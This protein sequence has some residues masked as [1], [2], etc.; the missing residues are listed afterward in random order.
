M[1]G[2]QESR[3]N[4]LRFAGCIEAEGCEEASHD[5]RRLQLC[6]SGKI[7]DMRRAWILRVMGAQPNLRF[8]GCI[9]AEGSEEASRVEDLN[10]LPAL[11][12]AG[13]TLSSRPPSKA[14]SRL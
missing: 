6:L 4:N 13:N 8:A 5:L 9:E 1:R 14:A 3:G 10:R 12:P 7:E 11:E 2:Y